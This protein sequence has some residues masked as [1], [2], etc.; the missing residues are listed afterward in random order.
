MRNEY[1]L[2]EN[3]D[4]DTPRRPVSGVP[5]GGGG[6]GVAPVPSSTSQGLDVRKAISSYFERIISA[7]SGMKV[8]LFDDD[9]KMVVSMVYTQSQIL[10]KSVFLT[11]S[12]IPPPLKLGEERMVRETMT[13]LKG[14]ILCRP[15]EYNVSAICRELESPLYGEYHVFFTGS[16]PPVLLSKLA[17]ADRNS[18]IRQVQEFYCDYLAVN[19]DLYDFGLEGSLKLS[20]PRNKWSPHIEE[21]L[22]RSL[23]GTMAV[24]LSLRQ[25]PTIRYQTGS[26]VAQ[27]FAQELLHE[28]DRE[29]SL[30]EFGNAA[31]SSN[32]SGET[33]LLVLDRKEDPVT[34]LLTQWTYQ[35]MVHD[36]LSLK[37]CVVDLGR[38]WE[39]KNPDKDT[40]KIVLSQSDEFYARMMFRDYG[41]L[42]D[43]TKKMLDDYKEKFAQHKQSM[44]SVEEM[45]TLVENLPEFKKLA[46][47]ALKHSA[48][49]GEITSLMTRHHLIEV[50][51][52]E[53]DMVGPSGDHA[54]HLERVKQKI[55]QHDLDPDYKLRLAMVY[56]IRYESHGG[57]RIGDVKQLLRQHRIRED[58]IKAIDSLLS[59]GGTSRRTNAS[60]LFGGGGDFFAGVRAKFVGSMEGQ[61]RLM[62]HK[63]LLS[64]ILG[65]I[66]T[67]KLLEARYPSVTGTTQGGNTGFAPPAKEVI[68]LI[69]GGV[70][71]EEAA[72]VASI[73]QGSV[74]PGSA[75]FKVLLGGTTV[76]NFKSFFDE[77]LALNY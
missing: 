13:H 32:S 8:V 27:H 77:L 60:E 10:D 12:L 23:Q 3:E 53:Q 20:K 35:A 1:A 6:G 58:Q 24:L 14:L 64:T 42:A 28:I 69:L 54:N 26:E 4:D 75:P 11:A 2:V 39:K 21:I 43:N 16:L 72:V 65:E 50:S 45:T 40:G 19:S 51:T 74:T 66:K 71:Y 46:N 68:V 17:E 29:R 22:R 62:Q 76:H 15:T 56:A 44:N 59:Y 38:E 9:T 7:V 70:T 49:V 34:P 57:N 55:S 5:R 36:L 61:N 41:A 18:V 31:P 63:P 73:N 47:N 48:V 67:G 25:R 37:H 52:L 33:L 30:F